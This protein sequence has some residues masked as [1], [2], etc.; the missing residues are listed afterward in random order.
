MKVASNGMKLNI[1]WLI[2]A[3]V[4]KYDSI[5]TCED[6]WEN[7]VVLL[8]LCNLDSHLLIVHG[9]ILPGNYE[10]QFDLADVNDTIKIDIVIYPTYYR[11]K[12]V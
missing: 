8:P 11:L 2:I 9:H 7:R 1:V 4:K 10:A 3:T 6:E 12:V 5:A